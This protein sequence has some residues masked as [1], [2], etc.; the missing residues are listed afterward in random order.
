MAKKRKISKRKRP[1]SL[2]TGEGLE[3]TFMSFKIKTA[4]PDVK[5]RLNY[6]KSLLNDSWS[7]AEIS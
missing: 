4:F 5:D 1:Y 7:T 2:L 3:L 6:I